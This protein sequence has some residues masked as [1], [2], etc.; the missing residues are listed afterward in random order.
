M[1]IK[2]FSIYIVFFSG[3]GTGQPC[4]ENNC[5]TVGVINAAGEPRLL[6]AR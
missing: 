3:N 5:G 2:A 4:S 6:L 1:V